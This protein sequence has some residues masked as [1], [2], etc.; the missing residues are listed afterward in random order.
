MLRCAVWY[1]ESISQFG[2]TNLMIKRGALKYSC[3]EPQTPEVLFDLERD[4][5]ENTNFLSE[6]RYQS[7]IGDFRARARELGFDPQNKR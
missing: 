6:A 3:Y 4:P 7:A 5:A 1:E 2:K